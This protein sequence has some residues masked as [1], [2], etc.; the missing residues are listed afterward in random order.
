MLLIKKSMNGSKIQ[1]SSPHGNTRVKKI[2]LTSLSYSIRCKK[3]D[4]RYS[5]YGIFL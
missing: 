2:G 4:C 1:L 3:F 5:F